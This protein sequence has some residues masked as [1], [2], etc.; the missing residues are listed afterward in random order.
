MIREMTLQA[1]LGIE[2]PIIQAPM[3]GVQ[4]SALAVAVSNAG[5]LGSLPCAMLSPASMRD[6]LE[7]IRAQTERPY[8]VNFFCHRTPTP[9]IERESA[10]RAARRAVLPGVR[11]RARCDSGS[12]DSPAV[13]RRGCG[14]AE[15]VQACGGQLSFRS[16]IAGTARASAQLG[17]ESAL[18]RHHDRRSAL[19]GGPRRRRDHRAGSRSGRPS[20]DVPDRR[21]DAADRARWRCC[22]RL[23]KP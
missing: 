6:E 5:G 15:L 1:L 8:N 7:R 16:A 4:G 13:Q 20:R 12:T 10:W 18:I 17:R 2:L 11:A 21:C 14:R 23:S 3:A 9:G 19:A 22:R